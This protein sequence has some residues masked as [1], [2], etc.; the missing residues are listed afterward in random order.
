MDYFNVY[1][2][3][4]DDKLTL[5]LADD[6][7]LRPIAAEFLVRY[8]D[9]TG[10]FK[11]VL[12]PMSSEGPVRMG[13][14]RIWYGSA[15]TNFEFKYT[16]EKRGQRLWLILES[17]YIR[18]EMIKLYAKVGDIRESFVKAPVKEYSVERLSELAKKYEELK[19]RQSG[20]AVEQDSGTGISR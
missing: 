2:P 11:E 5:D 19:Q 17:K 20:R 6:P 1:L 15:P 12:A 8:V 18:L 9:D 4:A 16:V 3:Y 14:D 7:E 10:P 13:R